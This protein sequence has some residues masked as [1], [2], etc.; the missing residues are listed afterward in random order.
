MRVHEDELSPFHGWLAFGLRSE[1]GFIDAAAMRGKV[2]KLWYDRRQ[3]VRFLFDHFCQGKRADERTEYWRDEQLWFDAF[4]HF[5][6]TV[7][8]RYAGTE[9][10]SNALS[11]TEPRKEAT[12]KLMT[13]TVLMIFQDTIL[14]AIQDLAKKKQAMEKVAVSATIPDFGQ[15]TTIVRTLVD[16]LTP[17][18]FQGWKLSGFDG[19]RGAREDLAD[20]IQKV[21][22]GEALP[23]ELKKGPRAHRLFRDAD[24]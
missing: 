20:A 24:Q 11:R 10:F 23:S 15:F 8:D 5:W 4:N 14:N 1:S 3:P 21:I 7:R 17:D 16:R 2:I 9:V 18:F 19:S 22:Q 6:S 12:S 13:A